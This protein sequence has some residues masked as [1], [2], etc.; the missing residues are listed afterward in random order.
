MN[1]DK[2]CHNS[3][4]EPAA[5]ERKSKKTHGFHRCNGVFDT[6]FFWPLFFDLHMDSKRI[7]KRDRLRLLWFRLSCDML[8]FCIHISQDEQWQDLSLFISDNICYKN[9][10][11]RQISLFPFCRIRKIVYLCPVFSPNR[12][13]QTIQHES[14]IRT[15]MEKDC[16]QSLK[17]TTNVLMQ[18]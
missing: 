16:K 12:Q 9:K 15:C 8:L 1:I 18:R 4:C 7:C 5:T 2:P 3:F 17:G 6:D 14:V 10:E 13:M 11:K